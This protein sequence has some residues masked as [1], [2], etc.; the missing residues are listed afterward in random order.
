MTGYL[1][2]YCDQELEL[3]L[4]LPCFSVQVKHISCKNMNSVRQQR[5]H[6]HWKV[7]VES[8]H[9]SGHTFR[10]RWTVQDLEVFLV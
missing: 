7:L 5:E 4:S 1:P 8:F 2:D 3:N 6:H 10:F 9:L